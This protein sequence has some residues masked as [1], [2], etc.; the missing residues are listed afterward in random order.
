[1]QMKVLLF[2]YN[3]YIM[4]PEGIS[5]LEQFIDYANKHFNEF[6]KLTELCT[7]NCCEPYFIKEDVQTAYINLSTV[8]K[9][10]EYEIKAILPKEEYK[11]RLKKI[12]AEKCVHCTS[13]T[14]L[15]DPD[16]N[17]R[18]HWSKISLDGECYGFDPK[19]E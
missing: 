19:K 4:Y 7:D 5:S 14:E 13:Y 2:D 15:P 18:R 8:E 17:L 9:I 6:V 1:M 11:K 10:S 3:R 12:L 16:E